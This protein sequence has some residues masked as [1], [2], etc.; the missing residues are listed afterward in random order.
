MAVLRGGAV[1]HAHGTPVRAHEIGDVYNRARNNNKTNLCTPR[2]EAALLD[3]QSSEREQI[4]FS[5]ALICTTSRR[6]RVNS[7]TNQRREPDDF[8]PLCSFRSEGWQEV[9]GGGDRIHPEKSL[10]SG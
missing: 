9:V 3:H 8:N 7:I 5:A 1:S 10:K 6:I 4:I 2:G